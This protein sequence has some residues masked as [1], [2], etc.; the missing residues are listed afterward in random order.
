[1]KE[2][3][4]KLYHW[5]NSWTGTIVIV[6]LVIF[7]LAQ[8]F[9]IP[10]GSMKK[11]LLPGD[12]LFAKKFAYGVPIPHI[13]WIEVPILPDFRG[14][15]HLIDGPRPKDGDIVIFRFPLKVKMHFVKRCFAGNGD[16]VIYDDKGFWL[17]PKNG[18]EYV[19]KHFKGFETKEFNG[20]LFVLN[21]YMKEH[22]GIHYINQ[23][24]TFFALRQRAQELVDFAGLNK[25]SGYV[26]YKE[27]KKIIN[28][29][30]AAAALQG[31]DVSPQQIDVGMGFY[32]KD[33][34]VQFFYSKLAKD[35]FLMI[36][37][38]RDE[39]F[40][41][42]FWGP[43]PYKLVVGKPWFIYMSWDKD[44][45]IRWNR[46]GKTINEIEEELREGKQPYKTA[47]CEGY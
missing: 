41:S 2:K 7:F 27:V 37:D 21:P 35:Y 14:D 43:V 15:G 3:L 24:V 40:D 11:T 6:L 8:A 26:P 36:G 23:N 25:Y 20:K 28:Q 19:K 38:N 33:G 17:H 39:S 29:V 18:N 12:A 9:V 10:S 16:E 47:G 31:E 44:F 13:P 1:M 30:I 32:L 34:K 45:T 5:S 42:R 22:R 46:V 4:K